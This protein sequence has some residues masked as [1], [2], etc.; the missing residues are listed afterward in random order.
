MCVFHRQGDLDRRHAES[1]VAGLRAEMR[2]AGEEKQADLMLLFRQ[3]ESTVSGKESELRN[4]F[5]DIVRTELSSVSARCALSA[6]SLCLLLLDLSL[7]VIHFMCKQYM[8]LSL[9]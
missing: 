5:V 3:L 2:R 1:D 6:S 8:Y 4:L 7:S 9:C